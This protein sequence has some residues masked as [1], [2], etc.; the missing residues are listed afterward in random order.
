MVDRIVQRETECGLRIACYSVSVTVFSTGA[1]ETA[2]TRRPRWID[3]L[4][5][6]LGNLIEIYYVALPT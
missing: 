4:R 2:A 6:E 3:L 1:R 5:G